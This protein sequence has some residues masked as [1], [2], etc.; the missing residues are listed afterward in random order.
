MTIA[1]DLTEDQVQQVFLCANQG[2]TKSD[3]AKEMSICPAWMVRSAKRLG[4]YPAL[5]AEFERHAA[6]RKRGFT[7]DASMVAEL[8]EIA[9][10]GTT[11]VL[12]AEH[13]GVSEVTLVKAIR[14]I[15]GLELEIRKLLM[16]ARKHRKPTEPAPIKNPR[17]TCP[18]VRALTMSWRKAA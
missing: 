8:E 15:P 5:N 16:K 14:A 10:T 7:L 4:I 3:A 2:C 1:T 17:D 18:V 13:F 11:K 6:V 12:I 9:A